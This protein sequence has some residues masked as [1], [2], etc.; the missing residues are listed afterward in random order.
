MVTRSKTR[1]FTLVELLV[2]I[3]I[4]GVLVALLLPAVQAA[5]EAARRN[6]CTN[7]LKQ[8]GLALL[9]HESTYKRFPLLTSTTPTI[10]SSPI[11]PT[12]TPNVWAGV[13]GSAAGASNASPQ[14]GYSWFV[15]ILPYLEQTVVAN[16]I[17]NASNKYCYPAF[18]MQ[19]GATGVPGLQKGPGLR[20]ASGGPS[21]TQSYWR[22]FSTLDMDEVR[23]PSFSGDN[24]T[25]CSLY[26][27]YSSAVQTDGASPAPPTPWSTITTNYK[28]LSA[29]HFAC[30]QNPNSFSMAPAPSTN[31]VEAPNGII[32]PPF[33][34][35][36]VILPVT[37]QGTA[38]RSILDGLS[39]TIIV[40]ETKEQIWS[41]WYDGTTSWMVAMPL[42]KASF[43][44]QM[45]STYNPIQPQ[46]IMMGIVNSGG[47]GA[48]PTIFY[49][50][51]QVNA[52]GTSGLNYGR[53]TNT[54]FA[55]SFGAIGASQAAWQYG[56]SSD[57]S[58]GLVLHVYAD[59]HVSPLAEDTDPTIYVQ[60]V[61]KAGREAASDPNGN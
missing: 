50:F 9:N 51:W 49:N 35:G 57:H 47:T 44:N 18:A 36:A 56:P 61:S 48:P 42:D 26:L 29:T 3:A 38:I 2:V 40:G 23:C 11:A 46:K 58:G 31:Y 15:K 7:K 14:A 52:G 20:Y 28:A 25:P 60:L 41:S 10:N 39:K 37:S 24:P 1:G 16:N 12:Y 5:R 43:Y 33:N 32:V 22:H 27:P 59:G 55:T 45:N 21:A 6:S 17:A 34:N 4:I 13:P 19:G 8:I 54:N 53:N 30:M